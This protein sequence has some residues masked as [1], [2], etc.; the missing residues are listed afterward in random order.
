MDSAS[1]LL[2]A[3]NFPG[4]LASKAAALVPAAAW[5]SPGS[6]NANMLPTPCISLPTMP[7]SLPTYSFASWMSL[8]NSLVSRSI[9]S[10]YPAKL[11]TVSA[12]ENKP[13]AMLRPVCSAPLVIPRGTAYKLSSVPSN[14]CEGASIISGK[15]GES[16]ALNR[17]KAVCG[18][19]IGGGGVAGVT[20]CC[21][22]VAD[23]ISRKLPACVGG[24][25]TCPGDRDD[26]IPAG[27]AVK[28]EPTP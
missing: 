4:P 27:G 8:K 9:A 17:S 19:G 11:V 25:I 21:I 20:G 7:S 24:I 23:V 28:L 14:S 5:P 6:A 3:F 16:K 22:G 12:I 2:L 1:I 10:S 18:S 15:N 26:E 13:S